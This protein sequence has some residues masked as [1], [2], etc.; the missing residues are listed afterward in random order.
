MGGAAAKRCDSLREGEDK[1]TAGWWLV[2]PRCLVFTLTVSSL[3][4]NNQSHPPL[5]AVSWPISGRERGATEF[6][7]YHVLQE[8]RGRCARWWGGI[9]F[10]W[11]FFQVKSAASFLFQPHPLLCAALLLLEIRKQVVISWWRT[12]WGRKAETD[13]SFKARVNGKQIIWD[14]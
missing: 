8:E 3:L 6:G 7:F 13:P 4:S 14:Y 1:N 11:C 9:F 12:Q 10:L 5:W 2:G